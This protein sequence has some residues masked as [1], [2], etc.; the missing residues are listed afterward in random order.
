[1]DWT[2]VEERVRQVENQNVE[3][4]RNPHVMYRSTRRTIRISV[5]I[6][7]RVSITIHLGIRYWIRHFTIRSDGM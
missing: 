1:M 6:R 7:T 3:I 2:A 5:N 4:W